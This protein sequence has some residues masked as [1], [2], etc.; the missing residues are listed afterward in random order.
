[1][2]VL[3]TVLNLCVCVCVCV[4]WGGVRLGIFVAP[5]GARARLDFAQQFV[6]FSRKLAARKCHDLQCE[7]TPSPITISI[8]NFPVCSVL[9]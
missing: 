9:F 4:G 3:G 2:I 8:W 1:M 6:Y 7:D 5:P